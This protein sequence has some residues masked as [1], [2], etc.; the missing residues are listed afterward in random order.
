[1][2]KITCASSALLALIVFR[3]ALLAED[4]PIAFSR[5]IRPILA[6]H[7]FKC[8]GPDEASR[9]ADLR[10]DTE[11][12]ARKALETEGGVTKLLDRVTSHDPDLVMP[13]PDAKKPL[14][15]AQIQ[16]LT[17]W[18]EA[19]AAWGSHWAFEPLV[20][21]MV[22]EVAP[23]QA[24][25]LRNPI[26]HFVQARLA[27]R[28]VLP[29]P[30]AARET[31][32]RRV[33][34]D[35]TGLP[36][37]PE[38]VESFVGDKS[39]DAWEK[40]VDRLL[41]S[42]A[43]GE[44]MAWSWLDAARYADSNGYQGDNERTM[45][46]WRDWVIDA[47][48]RN[49]PYDDFTVWQLAGDLLPDATFEQ[50][51]A[52]GFCRNHMI[53]GEG[54]RI[55]EENRVDYVLDMSETTGTVWLGLTLNCCRCHDHK[56]DPLTQHDYYRLSAFFN[57]TPV[58]GGGGN[59]QTPPVLEAPSSE[60]RQRMAEAEAQLAALRQPLQQRERELAESQD[61][62]ET[63]TLAGV[64]ESAWQPLM[65]VH[66][67]A[68]HQTLTQQEDGS[69]LAS[70]ENPRNDTYTIVLTN[71]VERITA[72]RIDA[73]KHE[74]HTLGGLARSDSGNFVL[75]EIE[76]SVQRSGEDKALPVKI[77]SGEASF[78]QGGFK[79]DRAFDG[80]PNTGWAVYDGKPIDREHSA[81]F[82][83]AETLMVE[84]DATLTI[85]LRHDSPHVSHN[86]GRFRLSAS[87][88]PEAH[89]D[90]GNN[91]LVTVLQISVV[92]RTPEQRQQ[93]AAAHRAAD[94]AYAALLT[95]QEKLK[96]SLNDLRGS[97]PKVMVMQDMPAP[98]QTWV[99]TRGIY[100]KHGDEVTAN[101]PEKLPQLPS[102]ETINRLALARWIVAD[103]NPLTARVT[104]NRFW[105]QF[106]GIGLVKTTE[107][108]GVQ[109]EIPIQQDLLDWLAADF[110]QHGWDV[111]RLVRQ[112]VTSH[113]YRQTS[114][115]SARHVEAETAS[116]GSHGLSHEVDPENRYL[117]RG[118]RFRLPSWMLRDQAL[119]A[120]GLLVR[121]IGG[122]PVKG[123]QPAGVWEET[124]FG[125]KQY[126]QEHG[127]ALFRRS[128]YTFWRR[129]IAPTMFFDN[130]TRQTCTVKTF[131]TNTPLHALLTLNDVTFVESARALA[132]HVL[133]A[134]I[135][136]DEGRI[137][138]VFR[139]LL[140]RRA[141]DS[142]KTIL[143]AAIGRSR[144]EFQAD[145]DAAMKL[146]AIGES[147]R[148]EQLNT[149]EHAAWTSLALAVMNLDE[150]LTKE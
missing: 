13:P 79:I 93:V 114:R 149:V 29:S 70:G 113:T 45:W 128:L 35:L 2:F 22:P 106:F 116:G 126:E 10:L 44:R 24:A 68:L 61:T 73:L 130:A 85:V 11:E 60:Q 33:T 142:E 39:D 49:L 19:G 148:N 36:P 115:I 4:T 3:T 8:H 120:S 40:V 78:E 96:K 141:T 112:I 125:R 26:D 132:E 84:K 89:L 75:T 76:I 53:N 5:D 15:P 16:L 18:V 123:Y 50:K 119:A 124:T 147:K 20:A 21:P 86:I 103:G 64:G 37:T 34:L 108:F 129:I 14:K 135:T 127:D 91:S 94:P 71:G 17:R 77:A 102:G 82:R 143:L 28:G 146:L 48:N 25:S 12:G 92:K 57:Q 69:I 55:A 134:D 58:D 104:V 7:C 95:E 1:M 109:G 97:F 111:K 145:P 6:G 32:I 138:D 136:D 47:F 100:S 90:G 87:A 144:G 42:P 117:S 9:E 88:S 122:P 137:D 31:L 41:S 67:S 118:P 133:M 54:G 107:D 99:L 105:Q 51:L 63:E 46:P 72:V 66:L 98:R 80:D 150:A 74:S 62:W 121:G 65:P 23:N 131:R 83:L 30:E 139:R 38:E 110:R 81:V 43:Y 59:A 27:A 140:A 52:T 101:V 56:F